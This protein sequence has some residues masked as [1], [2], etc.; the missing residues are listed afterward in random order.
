MGGGN[1]PETPRQRMIGMMYL[2][3]TA[4]LALNVSKDILN[5]FIV[6]DETL[7]KTNENFER[8]VEATYA[9]FG[10]AKANQPEKVGPFYEKALEVKEHTKKIIELFNQAKWEV[11]AIS[12]KKTPEEVVG[13][14]VREIK[15]KDD[16]STPTNYFI[17][18][19]ASGEAIGKAK[20]LKEAII[21]YRKTLL[22]YV[23]EKARPEFDKKI[24]LDV[25]GPFYDASGKKE[26]TWEH[27]S[28]YGSIMASSV[29]LL[30]KTIGEIRNA[31]FDILSY[32]MI[33]ITDGD[34]TFDNIS[35]KVIPNSRI[36]F[37]GTNFEADIIV[38]AFDSKTQPEVYYKLGIDEPTLDMIPSMEKKLG[39]SGMV[40]LSLPAAGIGEQKFAGFIKMKKPDGEDV[41]YPFKQTYSVAKS[42]AT[43]AAEKMNVFYAGIDNPVSASAPVPPDKIR[44]GGAGLTFRGS[45]GR[46]NVTP[47]TSMIGKTVNVTV[48]ADIDGKSQ[49]FGGTP[50]RIMQVP[51]P[52]I[53]IGNIRGGRRSKAEIVNNPIVVPKDQSFAFDLQWRVTGFSMTV[54]S[55]RNAKTATTGGNRFSGEMQGYINAAEPGSPLI[56]YD[57]KVTPSVDGRPVNISVNSDNLGVSVRLR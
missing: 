44:V 48:S 1:C 39:D 5:A 20:E 2:V 16:Y 53:A 9:Q 23:D 40:K 43:V 46:Y 37:T 31:E 24:G 32:L 33:A 25:V 57:V 28:F 14:T 42:T 45:G 34:F 21:E 41:Y 52:R 29:T 35:A 36:V 10:F 12:A 8:K 4:M 50:F 15:T 38:A 6:V 30:N 19:S 17:G 18:A 7:I 54:G 26:V 47:P 27:N 56:V 51:E 11:I 13:W 3:L 22:S 55:G 49:S